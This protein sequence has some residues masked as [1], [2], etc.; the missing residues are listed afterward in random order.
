MLSL[1]L[2]FEAKETLEAQIA[3]QLDKMEMIAQADEY[4]QSQNIVLEDFFQS[5]MH[6]FTH[7]E[8]CSNLSYLIDYN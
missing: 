2:E 1:W 5:T 3:S 4:E 7:P 8:V 6:Y